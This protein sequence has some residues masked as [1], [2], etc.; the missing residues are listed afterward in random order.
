MPQ[1]PNAPNSWVLVFREVLTKQYVLVCLWEVYDISAN[2][3]RDVDPKQ[4][5]SRFEEPFTLFAFLAIVCSAEL[6]SWR[7]QKV[8]FGTEHVRLTKPHIPS[9]KLTLNPKP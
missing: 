2:R 7:E 3:L 1:G 9:P 5:D 8:D 4:S 6:E